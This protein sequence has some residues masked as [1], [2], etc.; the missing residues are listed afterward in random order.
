MT[1]FAATKAM[2]DLPEGVI[3]LDGN[4]LGP[5]PSAA[6]DR[7]ANMMTEEWGKM[8][9]TGWNK[10]GW[11]QKSTAVGNRIARLIGAEEDHVIMGDT[12]SIK[13]Y[14]AVA[15]ALEMNPSRK[16]VLSDNGNFPSDLYIVQGLLKSL[17]AEYE[18]RVVD[19]EA[20]AEN[21]TD[22]VA[23]LM[24]TE[25]DY[26]TGRKHDMKTLTAKAHEAGALTVWDL[27]HSAGALPVELAGCKVDFAVGCTY[28][29]LNSGP[30]GPAFIYVAPRH[31]EVARPALSGWL[32]HE[33]PFAFDLDYRPGRGIERMR[34]GT[35][36]VI[37]LTSLEAAMDIW[38]QVDMQDLR[39]KSI[40]LCDLFI[41][42]VEA[43]CPELELA[44]PRDGDQRGS[45][46]SF[47][48]RE[49]Y[50]AMQALIQRGV[51][52]DFRA[53]DIMRFGFTP[54]YIDADDVRAAVAIVKD[55]MTND[56]WDNDAYKQRAA[57]T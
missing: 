16:V 43:A 14:Q 34:V 23:V 49:G 25:V 41:A 46:V 22:D 33:A 4:S 6:K 12:L 35:P 28:K 47:R 32:G 51:I 15:S 2:F 55:V 39:A 27:A 8:L 38:D 21:I 10:A 17:G 36:P 30:G 40:E 45:Q 29:Y 52:G 24:L 48:F 53:P 1:D 56:L 57:V 37:Q 54:L 26:R 5:L 19:P 13:V 42:E 9:I 31:A 3:Y 20:V 50:A 18:L 44:S 11:M 7:V